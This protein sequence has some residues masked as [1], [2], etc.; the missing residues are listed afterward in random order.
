MYDTYIKSNRYG[1]YSKINNLEVILDSLTEKDLL[2]RMK[3]LVGFIQNNFDKIKEEVLTNQ[4]S[5]CMDSI[6]NRVLKE[7]NA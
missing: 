2:P 6:I 7:D 3:K 1:K 4:K 5:V